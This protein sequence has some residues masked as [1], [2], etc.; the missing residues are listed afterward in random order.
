[1]LRCMAF[2]PTKR[3]RVQRYL[4][5]REPRTRE[6]IGPR[7]L[8]L[9]GVL[10]V[11]VVPLMFL[12]TTVEGEGEVEY[13]YYAFLGLGSM[14]VCSGVGELLYASRRRLAVLLRVSAY[15]VFLPSAFVFFAAQVYSSWG[16]ANGTFMFWAFVLILLAF[17]TSWLPK[18]FRPGVD[19]A[20]GTR[21][22][23]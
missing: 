13:V 2:A 10:Q 22:E 16:T 18:R 15:L 3:E 14:N 12:A 4:W 17:L 1:M 8:I 11:L 21:G 23:S 9:G 6:R 20:G 5:L 19:R 7:I